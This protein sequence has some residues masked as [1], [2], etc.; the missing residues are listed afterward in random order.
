MVMVYLR[1]WTSRIAIRIVIICCG[2]FECLS[3]SLMV[4]QPMRSK[5]SCQIP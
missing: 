4:N 3:F 5:K 1:A 2:G